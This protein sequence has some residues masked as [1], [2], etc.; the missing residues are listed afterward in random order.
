MKAPVAI[1]I[2]IRKKGNT[3]AITA[4][5]TRK[6]P[7]L[8]RNCSDMNGSNESTETVISQV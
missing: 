2:T 7:A 6:M 8:L 3:E 5:V 4:A 1:T